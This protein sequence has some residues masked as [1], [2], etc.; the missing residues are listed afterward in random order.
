MGLQGAVGSLPF[1]FAIL[2]CNSGACFRGFSVSLSLQAEG[3]ANNA[4]STEGM[5]KNRKSGAAKKGNKVADKQ[6]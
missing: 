4:V 6:Q 3:F 2:P 1:L 5:N